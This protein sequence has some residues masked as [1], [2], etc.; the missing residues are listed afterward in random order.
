MLTVILGLSSS[1]SYA[2]SDMVAQHLARRLG[3]VVRVLFWVLVTGVVLV[4]PLLF[5]V[6]GA[7]WHGEGWRGVGFAALA[8]VLYIGAYFCLLAG[9]RRG[10]LSLVAALSS[11]QGAFAAV[12]A[13][14]GGER[15]SLLMATGL[16]LAI[17][18]GVLAAVQGRAKSAAGA[19]WAL[20]SGLLFALVMVAYDHVDGLTWLSTAAISR[21]VS[22]VLFLPI[23]VVVLAWE[24]RAAASAGPCDAMPLA[25]DAVAHAAVASDAPRGLWLPPRLLGLAV[26]A[27]VFEVVGLVLVAASVISGPLAVAGVMASQFAT[28]ATVLGVVVLGE[29]PRWWQLVGV[30]LTIAGVSILGAFSAPG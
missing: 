19:G 26:V 27:G 1:L 15:L 18:G 28:F 14:L 30:A 5:I 17:C 16:V 24:R 23:V 22:F 20:A 29:R 6:E 7:G 3:G 11:T 9:F 8:G 4:V 13:V 21:V 25:A 12:F 10:D 2:V